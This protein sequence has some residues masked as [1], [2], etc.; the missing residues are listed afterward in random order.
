[1]TERRE[2]ERERVRY[3][4]V[5]IW[6]LKWDGRR[7]VRAY[8]YA[9]VLSEVGRALWRARGCVVVGAWR[10]GGRGRGGDGVVS[11]VVVLASYDPGFPPPHPES[12]RVDARVA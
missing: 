8:I 3:A 1:M 12:K 4:L 11:I 10:K 6:V 7:L 5:Y 2:R 9:F